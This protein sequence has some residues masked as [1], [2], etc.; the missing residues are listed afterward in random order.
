[1]KSV[2]P[3]LWVL[4]LVLVISLFL[5]MRFL[6]SEAD[7]CLSDPLIYGINQ[8]GFDVKCNCIRVT[9]D[10]PFNINNTD[11]WWAT[12]DYQPV[13]LDWGK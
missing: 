13:I 3:V 8:I 9:D 2:T 1:M 6:S 4:V 5:F 10:K 12:G 7:E 11:I